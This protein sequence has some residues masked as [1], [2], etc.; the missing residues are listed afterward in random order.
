MLLNP[1]NNSMRQTGTDEQAEGRDLSLMSL[2]CIELRQEKADTPGLL[3]FDLL[4]F[5]V[6]KK[7]LVSSNGISV[8]K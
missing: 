1:C 8:S 5:Q 7:N 3:N 6:K 4:V 2:L